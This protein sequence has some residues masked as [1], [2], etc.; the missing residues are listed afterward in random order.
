MKKESK[1]QAIIYKTLCTQTTKYCTS[2]PPQKPGGECRCSWI[3]RCFFNYIRFCQLNKK[4]INLKTQARFFL[5]LDTISNNSCHK[6]LFI[7]IYS[8]LIIVQ[9]LVMCWLTS[10]SVIFGGQWTHSVLCCV[11]VLFVFV[12]CLMTNLAGGSGFSILYYA[13]GIL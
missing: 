5:W 12:L 4:K 13:F 1:G 11:V 8:K 7:V 10:W 9:A 3:G 6:S 2:R